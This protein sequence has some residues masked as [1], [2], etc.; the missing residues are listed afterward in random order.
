MIAFLTCQAGTLCAFKPANSVGEKPLENKLKTL[1]KYCYLYVP[2]SVG[3]HQELEK[4]T[5]ID[6]NLQGNITDSTVLDSAGLLME[7]KSY[8]YDRT[9]IL[10]AV[11]QFDSTNTMQWRQNFLYNTQGYCQ[12]KAW[13]DSTNT[14]FRKINKQYNNLGD[15][16][17]ISTFNAIDS[18]IETVQYYYNNRGQIIEKR[19]YDS[20]RR[21]RR[22][23][24]YDSAGKLTGSLLY[25][26]NGQLEWKYVYSLKSKTGRSEKQIIVIGDK[27]VLTEFIHN[28]QDKF[29][30]MI[31]YDGQGGRLFRI[32]TAYNDDQSNNEI[33]EYGAD[34]QLELRVTFE[35]NEDRRVLKE[36]YFESAISSEEILEVPQQLIL[37]EYEDYSISIQS[38]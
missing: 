27:K 1:K 20:D 16:Y 37:Y 31:Q 14:L 2:D 35:Y 7:V 9:G 23:S 10:L 3:Y 24:E 15:I 13:F 12:E 18:T 34:N 32:V 33:T 26:P 19:W 8:L 30:E 17:Q 5:R 28:H 36:H 6:Y 29:S 11:R 22:K 4:I 25:Q 38:N 21:L